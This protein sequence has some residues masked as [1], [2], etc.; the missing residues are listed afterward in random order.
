MKKIKSSKK[1]KLQKWRSS[2][3]RPNRLFVEKTTNEVNKK[4]KWQNYYDVLVGVDPAY[5]NPAA[6]VSLHVTRDMEHSFKSSIGKCL[7]FFRK[8]L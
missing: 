2:S 7:I 5:R 8:S 3:R 6:G 1:T 4:S